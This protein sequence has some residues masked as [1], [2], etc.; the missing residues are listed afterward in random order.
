MDRIALNRWQLTSGRHW[1]SIIFFRPA[2]RQPAFSRSLEQGSHEKAG[3]EEGGFAGKAGANEGGIRLV[4]L[5]PKQPLSEDHIII[6]Y[7]RF[8]YSKVIP[9]SLRSTATPQR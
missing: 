5:I 7:A 8:A 4:D 3:F 2:A 9:D 1:K 6:L